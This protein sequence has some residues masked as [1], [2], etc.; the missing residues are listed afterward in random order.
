MTHEARSSNRPIFSQDL[1]DTA[2]FLRDLVSHRSVLV[3]GFETAQAVSALLETRPHH[4]PQAMVERV[5][6]LPSVLAAVEVMGPTCRLSKPVQADQPR[7][8]IQRTALA[9]CELASVWPANGIMSFAKAETTADLMSGAARAFGALA[10]GGVSAAEYRHAQKALLAVENVE[11]LALRA[12]Y[13]EG[14]EKTALDR[15]VAAFMTMKNILP[16]RAT[17]VEPLVLPSPTAELAHYTSMITTLGQSLM[18]TPLLVPVAD[19][20]R[21]DTSVMPLSEV[22]ERAG[23]IGRAFATLA[24]GY[25]NVD[26]VMVRPQAGSV[27]KNVPAC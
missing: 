12:A 19:A 9:L 18:H 17:S 21:V 8:L 20:Y 6:A 26:G 7:G 24:Q 15:H 5:D 23:Q 4:L 25:R 1:T 10:T 3:K 22:S 27:R 14:P 13:L 11:T 2:K 16:Y